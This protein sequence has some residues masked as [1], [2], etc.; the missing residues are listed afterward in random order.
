[1]IRY[2]SET[3]ASITRYPILSLVI[4]FVIFS[5]VMLLLFSLGVALRP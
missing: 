4:S 5:L 1:M 3:L 2:A